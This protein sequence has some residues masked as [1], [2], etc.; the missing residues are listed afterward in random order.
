ML[1]PSIVTSG[2][3]VHMSG[4]DLRLGMRG[5]VLA[6][7]FASVGAAVLAVV[8]ATSPAAFADD[9]DDAVA[10][11]QELAR[12]GDEARLAAA[13]TALE[14]RKDKRVDDA[15]MAL[16]RTSRLDAGVKAAMKVLALHK[17]PAYVT[18][19]RSKLADERMLEK[20]AGVYLAMLDSLPLASEALKPA[21]PSLVRCVDDA[22]KTR[23][24]VS[25]RC[26]KAMGGCRDRDA[27]TTLI[28]LLEKIEGSEGGG[29][30]GGGGGG[31]PLPSPGRMSGGGADAGGNIQQAKDACAEALKA[32]TGADGGATALSWKT[33]WFRN[34]KTF[35][36]AAPEPDW[37]TLVEFQDELT[38]VVVRKPEAQGWVFERSQYAGGRA[39]ARPEGEGEVQACLD[40]MTYPKGAFT[41]SEAYVQFLDEEWRK[42]EF[43][44]F[45]EGGEPVVKTQRIGGREF[46][47]ITAKGV[48]AGAW[49]DWFT[50][51]RRVYVT[52]AGA[53]G[54][55]ALEA[56]ARE[57]CPEAKRTA[58][59]AALESIAFKPVK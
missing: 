16:V 14:K 39:R 36:F 30:G 58:L 20:R 22:L 54:F 3:V 50:C 5:V 4:W 6:A 41:G 1:P 44:E 31:K 46:V 34:G 53:E 48:G 13:I 45:S 8:C 43:A 33:W 24:D 18:W 17:D 37:A 25:T 56:S 59:W 51:E 57:T 32:L 28:A 7:G 2:E 49:K 42:R 12:G 29:A 55:L 9:V 15:L 52:S 27:V 21:L 40:V 47:V 23:P 38:G 10:N 11:V 26:I 19:A 35:R